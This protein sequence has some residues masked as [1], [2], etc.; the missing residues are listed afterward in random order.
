M[1]WLLLLIEDD[2]FDVE[3]VR[4]S[5]EDHHELV[6]ARTLKEAEQKLTP[7]VDA[8]IVDLGLPD[9]DFEEVLRWIEEKASRLAVV[10]Y[11]GYPEYVDRCRERGFTAVL[12]TSE[13]YELDRLLLEAAQAV[14]R[15]ARLH[16]EAL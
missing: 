12:K 8:V 9:A 4:R 11:S 7:D 10:I 1:Q 5:L 2:D 14:M 6:V 13:R 15:R 16:L 3:A